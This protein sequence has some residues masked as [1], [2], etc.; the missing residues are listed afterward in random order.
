MYSRIGI[1]ISVMTDNRFDDCF[2]LRRRVDEKPYLL[3]DPPL[4]KALAAQ[5]IGKNSTEPVPSDHLAY[6][7]F[8]SILSQSSP[9][10]CKVTIF[11]GNHKRIFLGKDLGVSARLRETLE[12]VIIRAGGKLVDRVENAQI[13]IGCYREKDDYIQVFISLLN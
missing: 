2:K 12:H 9:P 10:P 8:G 6:T 3:P 4:F 11:K 5:N 7:H 13:Y 1:P